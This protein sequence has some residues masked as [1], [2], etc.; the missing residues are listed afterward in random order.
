MRQINQT[1]FMHNRL[2]MVV[3]SFLVKDLLID[4]R[5]GEQYFADNLNDFDLAVSNGGWQWAA[6]T[7][8]DAQ[9]YCRRIA[10]RKPF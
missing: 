9:P 3:A 8:R 4:R 5:W 6:P 2:R 7:G 10:I 1:G